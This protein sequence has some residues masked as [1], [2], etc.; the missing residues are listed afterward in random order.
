MDRPPEAQAI[1][2]EVGKRDYIKLKGHVH[3]EGDPQQTTDR[4]GKTCANHKSDKISISRIHKRL[5]AKQQQQTIQL[6]NVC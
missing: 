1:N 4:V 5:N 6:R 2:A 3:R